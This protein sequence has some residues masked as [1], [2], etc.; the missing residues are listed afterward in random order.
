MIEGIQPAMLEVLKL[1]GLVFFIER[2]VQFY[3]TIK[4]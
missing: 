2:G 1:F 3:K 4:E